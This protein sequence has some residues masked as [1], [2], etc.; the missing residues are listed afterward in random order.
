MYLEYSA[1]IVLGAMALAH[2]RFDRTYSRRIRQLETETKLLE[3]D[4]DG[5]DESDD[6]LVGGTGMFAQAEADRTNNHYALVIIGMCAGGL[7]ILTMLHHADVSEPV[8][9]MSLLLLMLPALMLLHHIRNM[10]T[11]LKRG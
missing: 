4:V 5:Y 3:H 10:C 8:G 2:I 7:S 6:V 11:S 9:W 1:L